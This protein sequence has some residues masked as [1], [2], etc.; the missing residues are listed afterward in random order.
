MMKKIK[1]YIPL[2]I[3]IAIVA[4]SMTS[5]GSLGGAKSLS[6]DSV[7]IHNLQYNV[8]V[9]ADLRSPL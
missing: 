1:P 2:F 8:D 4:V 7:Y 5:C 6:V 3:L 9:K